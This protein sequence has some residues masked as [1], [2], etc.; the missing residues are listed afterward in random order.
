MRIHMIGMGGAG[1]SALARL[2]LEQGVSLSGSDQSAS[3]TLDELRTLGAAAYTGSDPARLADAELVVYSSAVPETDAELS[4][5]RARGTRAIK[6]AVALGELFNA[7]RG[8]AVAGT[9]GKTTTSSMVSLIL[10]RA[11]LRPAFHVGGELVDLGTSARWGDGEWFVVEAD[12][13]DRRFLE[14]TPEVATVNNVEPDHFEYYG[15]YE[16][17]RS[18]FADFLRRL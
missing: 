7:R 9:H 2:Y 3:R 15:T 18:A 16:N 6:H 11:G 17:M 5:A 14:Y 10:E 4:A 8:I 13:F 1:M 12:E